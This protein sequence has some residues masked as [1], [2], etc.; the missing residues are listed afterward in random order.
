MLRQALT[1]AILCLSLTFAGCSK[2]DPAAVEAPSETAPDTAAPVAETETQNT[3]PPTVESVMPDMKTRLEALKPDEAKIPANPLGGTTE[4]SAEMENTVNKILDFMKQGTAVLEKVTDNDSATT[5][6]EKMRSLAAEFK[7]V[8]ESL[9]NAA[10][11]QMMAMLPKFQTELQ[12]AGQA[13]NLAMTRV[14]ANEEWKTIMEDVL[15]N[16]EAMGAPSAPAQ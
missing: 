14:M 16:L 7:P 11:D 15:K 1:A 10:P 4:L 5:A 12:T 3:A 8:M 13:F 6:A 2:K 9:K